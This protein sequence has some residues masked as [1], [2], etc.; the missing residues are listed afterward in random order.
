[1]KNDTA[2]FGES[3]EIVRCKLLIVV[4]VKIQIVWDMK[5]FQLVSSSN[6]QGSGLLRNVGNPFRILTPHHLPEG[7]TLCKLVTWYLKEEPAG[8]K[9]R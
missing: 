1:M 2:S 9:Q 6:L 3:S 7:E 5:L 8:L 4:L